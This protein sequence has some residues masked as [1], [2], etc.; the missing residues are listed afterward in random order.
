[1]LSNG[2]GAKHGPKGQ[3]RASKSAAEKEQ[4]KLEIGRTGRKGREGQNGEQGQE[5]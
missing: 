5:P 1:M 3:G 4:E 2:T